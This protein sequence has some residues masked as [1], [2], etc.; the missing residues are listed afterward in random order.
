MPRTRNYAAE[1]AA[2]VQR[3]QAAGISRSAAR[4]HAKPGEITA[5][6]NRL[7][8]QH[9][10]TQ[11]QAQQVIEMQRSLARNRRNYTKDSDAYK[12]NR[13]EPKTAQTRLQTII[14]RLI[15]NPEKITDAA[16][17]L[18]GQAAD[19]GAPMRSEIEEDVVRYTPERKKGKADAAYTLWVDELEYDVMDVFDYGMYEGSDY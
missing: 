8:V 13:V 6:Q 18:F 14:N 7:M 3:A 2:R 10:L 5:S 1:Y 9:N 4:G 19:D 12:A 17:D 15:R 16:V 11:Q